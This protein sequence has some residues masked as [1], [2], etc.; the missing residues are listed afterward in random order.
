VGRGVGI[1]VELEARD[2]LDPTLALNAGGER[3]PGEGEV[4]PDNEGMVGRVGLG[5]AF[6]RDHHR[7]RMSYSGEVD[8]GEVARSDGFFGLGLVDL[9]LDGKQPG[10]GIGRGKDAAHGAGEPGILEHVELQVHRLAGFEADN[11]EFG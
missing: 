9:D 5:D 8:A 3:L 7:V 10:E 2:H 11:I 6:R 4:L 1:L